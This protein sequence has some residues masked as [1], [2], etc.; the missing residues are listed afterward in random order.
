[1]MII[2]IIFIIIVIIVTHQVGEYALSLTCLLVYQTGS[3]FVITRNIFY[4]CVAARH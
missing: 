2:G 1:M 4:C 3:Y